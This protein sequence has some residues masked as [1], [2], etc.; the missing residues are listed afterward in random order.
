MRKKSK[1]VLPWS[2][3]WIAEEYAWATIISACATR[4]GLRVGY[5][6]VLI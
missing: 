1:L 5:V 2:M 4:T 3:T 6:R